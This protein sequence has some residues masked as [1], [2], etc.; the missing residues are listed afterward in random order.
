MGDRR[1]QRSAIDGP[2]IAICG[3]PNCGAAGGSSP[4][5][6]EAVRLWNRR[7]AVECIYELAELRLDREACELLKDIINEV[8]HGEG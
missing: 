3:N 6:E 8:L 4:D 5:P 1:Q 7:Y 2:T